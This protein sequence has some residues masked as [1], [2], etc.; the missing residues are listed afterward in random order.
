VKII[1]AN[2][3]T[4]QSRQKSYFD[5]RRKP[6]QFEV[7]SHV[8]LKVS[9]IR[10][11][12]RFGVRGK[13]APRYVGPYEIV[14]QCGPVAYRLRLPTPLSAVHDVFHVSQLKKC[15]RVP[16]EVVDQEQIQLE[17]DL[18][19]TAQPAQVLDQKERSTRRH[20]VKM[21]KILWKDHTEEE[22]TWETEEYL[23]KC[24]PGFLLVARG[25]H[26][27]HTSLSH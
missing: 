6:L 25:N 21:Y 19:Y 27:N 16:T 8:Y 23:N 13:L 26:P 17:P 18:T 15:T 1:Q 3:K 22:A 7:G 9:P 12:Q 10:G 2:L 4:A 5:K 20:T 11:V 24:Y 14:E